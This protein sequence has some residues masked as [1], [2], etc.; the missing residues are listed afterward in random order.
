MLI[1]ATFRESPGKQ[2]PKCVDKKEKKIILECRASSTLQIACWMTNQTY[3]KP[4][5]AGCGRHAW[6]RRRGRF[7]FPRCA[8]LRGKTWFWRCRGPQL[9]RI[10]AQTC[11]DSGRWRGKEKISPED[12]RGWNKRAQKER[13]IRKQNAGWRKAAQEIQKTCG[14]TPRRWVCSRI[15]INIALTR[16]GWLTIC[17]TD[18][19]FSQCLTK[20]SY[21]DAAIPI[22]YSIRNPSKE[23]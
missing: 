9:R 15:D 7:P 18:S 23:Q 21:I 4:S 1:R 11:R 5:P 19:Q 10:Q 20:L 16:A 12:R 14:G 17:P 13:K 6:R 3:T 22:W 8:R 2:H